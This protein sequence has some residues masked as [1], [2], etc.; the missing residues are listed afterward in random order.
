MVRGGVT[1]LAEVVVVARVDGK[2]QDLRV[3]LKDGEKLE[4]LKVDTPEG[5]DAI[6]HTAEH[7]M[8]TAVLNLFPNAKVTMG[9]QSHSEEFYYDFDMGGRAFSP[10][11]LLKIE[12]EMKKIIKELEPTHIIVFGD[13]AAAWFLPDEP[14]LEKKRGWVFDATYAGVEVKVC[15]TLDLQPLYVPKKDDTANDDDDDDDEGGNDADVFGIANLLFYVSQN[16]M[17]GL[18]GRNLYE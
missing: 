14:V 1:K 10:D 11:D 18:A 3:P 6:N 4:L 8:A 17:N 5:R 15:P 2:V 9:P 13:R 16:V 7:V 12:A